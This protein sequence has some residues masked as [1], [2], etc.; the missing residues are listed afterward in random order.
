MHE[1]VEQA[2]AIWPTLIIYE[3][4]NLLSRLLSNLTLVQREAACKKLHILQELGD[5]ERG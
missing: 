2:Q 5:R 3:G 1:F 4:G